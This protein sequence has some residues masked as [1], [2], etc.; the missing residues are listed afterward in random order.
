MDC[1]VHCQQ[2]GALCENGEVG[3]V[4][5]W[6]NKL[7]AVYQ[8]DPAIPMEVA[9][10]SC[11]QTHYDAA[12]LDEILKPYIGRP[13]AFCD[14]LHETWGWIVTMDL[15]GKR[16]IADENKPDCVCPLVKAAAVKTPNLCNC[17]EG[18]AERMFAKVLGKPVRARVIESVLRG[19]THCMYEI[20]ID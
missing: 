2:V 14:F 13:Q 16:I 7:L 19:G 4:C 12:N 10:K 5:S 20:V 11:S 15:D 17:S 18:F 3:L 1:A 6:V 9:I 8:E